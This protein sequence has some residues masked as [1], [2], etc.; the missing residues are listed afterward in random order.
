MI[1]YAVALTKSPD[2]PAV[3]LTPRADKGQPLALLNA[4]GQFY[5]PVSNGM[6]AAGG[7]AR[8]REFAEQN[9][10]VTGKVIERGGV[11]AIIIEQ[12]TKAQANVSSRSQRD[13]TL[14]SGLALLCCASNGLG[15]ML[16]EAGRTAD[17][18]PLFEEAVAVRNRVH[19]EIHT[20]VAESLCNLG[21]FAGPYRAPG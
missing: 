6:G 10:K 9:A 8:L 1:Q 11:K 14:A 4:D 16:A 13:R 20:D 15:L 12:I 5:L 21:F 18:I 7:N 19:G 2:A 3:R 17:G